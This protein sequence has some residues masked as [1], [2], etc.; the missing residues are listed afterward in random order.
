MR[1]IVRILVV[2]AALLVGAC[3]REDDS[4]LDDALSKDLALAS[5]VQPYQPQQFVSPMEMG[6]GPYGQPMQYQTMQQ[7]GTYYPQRQP[8]YQQ[9]VYTQPAPVRRTST[10]SRSSGTV[11]TAE[12]IRNTKRDAVIGAAAGATIG[13]VTSKDKLKGAVIGAVAGGVLGG[14]IGHTV[15]V[16]QP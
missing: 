15:D 12:P 13:A 1:N 11:R 8:V 6:Y 10:V 3:G 7:P 2:P 4:R 16:K 9:P 14:I 5:Q